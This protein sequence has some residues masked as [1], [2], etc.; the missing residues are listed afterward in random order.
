M[1]IVGPRTDMSYLNGLAIDPE[2]RRLFVAH[3]EGLSVVDLA[4]GGVVRIDDGGGATLA[5]IDGLVLRGRTHLGDT[6]IAVQPS[7]RRAIQ[8]RLDP[9][10]QRLE[11]FEVLTAHHPTMNLPTTGALAG[12]TYYL[13][14]NSQLRV[15]NADRSIPWDRLRDPVLLAIDLDASTASK[16]PGS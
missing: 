16:G 13:L 1:P 2:R 8:I 4:T 11:G 15:R 7:L 12:T 9:A 3:L 6:L 14:A 10:G 5:G